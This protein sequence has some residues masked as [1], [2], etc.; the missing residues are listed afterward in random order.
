[1]N[2]TKRLVQTA[3][4]TVGVIGLIAASAPET[5]VG[6]AARK[7]ARRLA[8][9]VRYVASSM[10]GIS[11]R[12]SGRQPDPDVSDDILADRIRSSIGPLEKSLDIPHVHVM[13]EDHVAIIHGDVPDVDDAHS[14]AH[15][16]MSVSGVRGVESHLHAGLIAG[17]TR[18]SQGA[19][20]AAPTSDALLTLLAAAERSGAE[21][22]RAAVH[23]VLCAFADRIPEGERDQMLAHLP[24]DVRTLAGPPQRHGERPPRV[25]TLEQLVGAAMAEGGI[26]RTRATEITRTIVAALR[27]LVPDEADDVAAVLPAELR[28]AWESGSTVPR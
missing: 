2:I 12:L 21:H 9:D 7:V 5:G 4:L 11:Y 15:A 24:A 18:P 17:D 14:I 20:G 19:A 22:P 28:A 8:R 23:A 3:G 25:K 13:V 10:P 16:I 27:A 1:M 26:E 6:R